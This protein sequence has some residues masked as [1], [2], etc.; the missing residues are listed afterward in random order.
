[1]KKFATKLRLSE[2]K[3]NAVN[4]ASK[5]MQENSSNSGRAG[6]VC[7]LAFVII[8]WNFIEADSAKFAF[9]QNAQGGYLNINPTDANKVLRSIDRYTPV[10]MEENIN[11]E[12]V[13]NPEAIGGFASADSVEERLITKESDLELDYTVKGG[14]TLSSI[15]QEHGSTVAT[16]M[17]HNKL[18]LNGIENLKLGTVIKIPPKITSNSTKWL[19][20]LQAKRAKDRIIAS[21]SSGTQRSLVGYGS[22][23]SRNLIV[24]L[25]H[26]GISR[27]LLRYHFGIDYMASPNTP[28][29]ASGNGRVVQIH[30]GCSKNGYIGNGCGGGFGNYVLID[31]GG[32]LTTRY[33]HLSRVSIGIGQVVSQRQIIGY[34]GNSGNSSGPHLHFETRLH[35]RAI[36]PY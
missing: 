28:V 12:L 32:G 35:G 8:F 19:E 18:D 17:E 29:V 1:M 7:L 23:S 11:L 22:V 6:V 31:H 21:R 9:A 34:S 5:A 2:V 20:D 26:K 24:P 3:D 25:R 36:Y 4:L 33:A 16:L 13:Y 27:G 14:D 15:A 10:L 30:T